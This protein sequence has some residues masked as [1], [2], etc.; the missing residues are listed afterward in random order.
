MA[1]ITDR[2]DAIGGHAPEP[3]PAFLTAVKRRRT[4]RRLRTTVGVATVAG[5]LALVVLL[6]PGPPAPPEDVRIVARETPASTFA[7]LRALNRG[8]GELI[9]PTA[10]TH[11][12]EPLKAGAL[13]RTRDPDLVLDRL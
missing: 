1:D 7:E 4:A 10:R 9:L 8:A 12:V 11:A 2:L 5:A 3:S 13:L 6:R